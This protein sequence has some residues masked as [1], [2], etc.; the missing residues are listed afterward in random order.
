MATTMKQEDLNKAAAK[1][2][3][4]E[5]VNEESMDQEFQDDYETDKKKQENDNSAD[6]MR[7]YAEQDFIDET[8][9][10][11]NSL[12]RKNVDNGKIEIGEYLLDE[13]FKGN[14][15]EAM[16]TN[17]QKH[18]T[19]AKIAEREDLL[20]EA[21]TLGSW[22]RAA[23]VM[24]NLKEQGINLPNLTTYHYVELATVRDDKARSALAKRAELQKFSVKALREEI[25]KAK[26]RQKSEVENLKA[27][28]DKNMRQ[29]AELNFNKDLKD[30]V[31][32][33]ESVKDAYP[34]KKAVE[35][36]PEVAKC[37]AAVR[38]QE[39]LFKEFHAS[40][41]SIVNEAI[42]PLSD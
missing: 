1:G 40:L 19:F 7:D 42:E 25:R 26:G 28:M 30:F 39:K 33:I 22:V 36:L 21:K 15:E 20:V 41:R 11:I 35:V 5:N 38:I 31:S 34:P 37:L 23:A 9:N 27:D 29:Y 10:M 6:F 8:V 3:A 13:V 18:K 16:S 17:P 12:Y 2:A 4:T 14:A 32:D 24:R